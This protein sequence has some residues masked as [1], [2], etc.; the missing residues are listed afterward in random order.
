MPRPA[1]GGAAGLCRW[2]VGKKW[3]GVQ[4]KRQFSCSV[5]KQKV[6]GERE[7]FFTCLQKIIKKKFPLYVFGIRIF[8]PTFEKIIAFVIIF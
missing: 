5:C 7:D 6:E 3:R 1:K 8:I 4:R 2:L